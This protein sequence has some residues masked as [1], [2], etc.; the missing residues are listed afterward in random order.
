MANA[1]DDSTIN[2][3]V[4][5]III[6]IIII[7]NVLSPLCSSTLSLDMSRTCASVTLLGIT[8]CKQIRIA[9]ST[10]AWFPALRFRSSDEIGSSSIFPYPFAP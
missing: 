4:V 5:I 6:I 1:V 8:R 9:V 2:I 7:M 10:N 3:V